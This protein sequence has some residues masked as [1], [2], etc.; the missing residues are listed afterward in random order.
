[1]YEDAK[2]FHVFKKIHVFWK[3]LFNKESTKQRMKEFVDSSNINIL[4]REYYLD[5]LQ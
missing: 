3:S 1:M 5:V 4:A 2:V